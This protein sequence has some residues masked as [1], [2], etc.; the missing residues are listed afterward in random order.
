MHL[1]KF[2][3]TSNLFIFHPSKSKGC[4]FNENVNQPIIP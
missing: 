1:P 2:I 3:F 4:A